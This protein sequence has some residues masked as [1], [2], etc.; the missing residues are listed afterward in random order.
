MLPSCQRYQ[1]FAELLQQMRDCLSQPVDVTKIQ[2]HLSSVQ[3][4]FQQQIIPLLEEDDIPNLSLIQSLHTETSKQLRLLAMDVLFLHGARQ[5]TTAKERLD[6]ISNRIQTLIQYSDAV[7]R[8]ASSLRDIA[9]N[10]S[11]SEGEE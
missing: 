5:N 9:Q 6:T 1:K 3:Q 2:K 10:N 4:F 8:S 7:A 11:L